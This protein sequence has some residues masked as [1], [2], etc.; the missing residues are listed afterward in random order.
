VV[1]GAL[2]TLD[3]GDFEFQTAEVR[4]IVHSQSPRKIDD[5]IRPKLH[6]PNAIG[7]I[8]SNG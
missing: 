6:I 3:A 2:C 1:G 5:R 8:P 7:K 4:V